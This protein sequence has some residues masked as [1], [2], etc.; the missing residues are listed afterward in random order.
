MSALSV[1]V[2]DFVSVTVNISP[3]AV[4]YQNFGLPLVIGDSGIIDTTTR[5]RVYSNIMG[6]GSDFG[7]SAPEYLAAQTFFQQQPQPAQIMIGSWAR[8]NIAGKLIGATLTAAQYNMSVFNAVS[9]GSFFIWVNGIPQAVTGVSFTGLLTQTAVASALATA[10]GGGVSVIWNN[11]YT[12]FEI[13]SSTSGLGSSVSLL[14][15][16]NALGSITFLGNPANGDYITI[17]GTQVTFVTSGATGNQINI[18]ATLAIT[19]QSLMTFLQASPDVNLTK[20]FYSWPNSG[21]VIYVYSVLTGT[22]GNAYTLTQSAGSSARYTLSGAT[23]S[24]GSGTDISGTMGGLL[25]AGAYPVLGVNAETPLAAAQA[26]ANASSQWYGVSFAAAVMPTPAQYLQVAAYILSSSRTRIFGVTIQTT[27]CLNPAITYD[28]ASQLQ[29]V[30]NKRVFWMYSSTNPYACMTLFGRAFTVNFSGQ[31]TTITLAYKQA[32][33]VNGESLTESQ[34]AS[35]YGYDGVGGKGGNV[36]II[37]NNGA[38]MIWPGQMSNGNFFDEVHGIDWQQNR[39]Q[40][41]LFNLLYESNTKIPQTN[42]GNHQ[43]A[44]EIESSLAAGVNNGLLA[45]GVWTS[46]ETFGMLQ[47]GMALTKGY[48]VYCPPVETQG[49][50]DR[51]LRKSVVIQ[52]AAKM[53]GAI[54]FPF[55]IFNVNR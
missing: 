22:A 21:G 5:Y 36:N 47:T 45:P 46:T 8:S 41:D 15:P 25:A 27:D 53:A 9:S 51:A 35:I 14:A 32:P 6:V 3:M 7:S 24:G 44:T 20:L 31:N 49:I 11:I 17:A 50:P 12:R 19:Q 4:P 54:H 33:G 37:V 2:S 18:G 40:T 48:Y 38:T 34:A 52:A 43:L 29:Q 26:C 16:P 42:P 30:N 39:I 23:L 55:V 13:S 10:I 28:L 1:D